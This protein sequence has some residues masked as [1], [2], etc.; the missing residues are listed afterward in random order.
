MC[1]HPGHRAQDDRAGWLCGCPLSLR[2]PHLRRHHYDRGRRVRVDTIVIST[3]HD[4][5]VEQAEIRADAIAHIITPVIPA[6]C[7]TATPRSSSIRPGASSSEAPW[8]TP[9]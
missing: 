9:D 6:S 2:L 5:H 8:A 1:R 7:W 4:D 3:Q